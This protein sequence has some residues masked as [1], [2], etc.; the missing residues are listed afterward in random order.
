[1][2]VSLGSSPDTTW[3]VESLIMR[4]H[5]ILMASLHPPSPS[6]S[7]PGSAPACANA[8]IA[9]HRG[10]PIYA[11]L[12]RSVVLSVRERE[13]WRR[14]AAGQPPTGLILASPRGAASAL[15][16]RGGFSL[17]VGA[18]SS[19]PGCPSSAGNQPADGGLG[20]A[21]SATGGIRHPEPAVVLLRARDLR[22]GA[23]PQLVGDAVR[24]LS[25]PGRARPEP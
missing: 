9:S 24:D 23:G 13:S 1:M 15:A 4:S 12:V 5:D 6:P 8:M 21:C 25:I 3:L 19:H 22:D 16:R 18:R 11:R 17:D 7:W 10:L 20:G 2:G 14:R